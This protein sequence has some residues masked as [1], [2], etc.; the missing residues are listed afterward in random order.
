MRYRCATLTEEATVALECTF[1]ETA[2]YHQYT[3]EVALKN[4][5]SS[6]FR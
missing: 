1:V 4:F 2:V 5:G 3:S 6:N